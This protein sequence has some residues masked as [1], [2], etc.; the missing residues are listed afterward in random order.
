MNERVKKMS[1]DIFS[2]IENIVFCVL[3]VSLSTKN[4]VSSAFC[5]SP[6]PY[7]QGTGYRE[8]HKI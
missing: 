4:R 2:A 1:K 8:I 6:Y 7:S 5:H 3:Y